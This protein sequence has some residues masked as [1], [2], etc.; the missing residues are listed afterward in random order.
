MIGRNTYQMGKGGIAL[1]KA[2]GKTVAQTGSNIQNAFLEEKYGKE[3]AAKIMLEKQQ[4]KR[5][6]EYV[7]N[8]VIREEY[9]QLSREMA[10]QGYGEIP[11]ELL[12]KA[13]ADYVENGIPDMSK[14]SKGL[15]IEAKHGGVGGKNHKKVQAIM[16]L[17]NKYGEEY[18]YD[19]KKRA[20]VE[21][22]V[23]SKIERKEDQK[24]AM[25]LLAEV[26]G[27]KN[28]EFY[29]KHGKFK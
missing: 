3:K 14:I 12:Q 10:A 21:N 2:A 16:E 25:L 23:E 26:H 13:G 1:G 28:G 24:E 20:I 9:E 17:S 15:K 11:P 7:K 29:K 6:N 22:V 18:I 8:K 4:E 27:D 5:K 19:D